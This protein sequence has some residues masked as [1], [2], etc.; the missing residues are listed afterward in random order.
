MFCWPDQIC[1][2]A[3]WVYFSV[4]G[5]KWSL[6]CW[7]SAYVP[8]L[9]SD[10]SIVDIK[11]FSDELCDMTSIFRFSFSGYLTKSQCR[12]GRWRTISEDVNS[13]PVFNKVLFW[14][15]I[16]FNGISL[17][18]VLLTGPDL[19]NSLLGVLLRFRREMIAVTADIQHMF[20]VVI[21]GPFKDIE[22]QGVCW[23]A[24]HSDFPITWQLLLYFN[25]LQSRWSPRR[26]DMSSH[27]TQMRRLVTT[28]LECRMR[29]NNF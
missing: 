14:V 2:T 11:V 21:F 5:G 6:N 3:F 15:V 7:H 25:W 13:H 10:E 29:T 26:Q 19:S 23:F 27:D 8:L 28:N 18:N 4:F 17:N 1:Q 20:H 24:R 16:S 9:H 12:N 22:L